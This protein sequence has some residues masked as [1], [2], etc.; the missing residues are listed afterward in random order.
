ML[1]FIFFIG[2]N[3]VSLYFGSINLVILG[4]R[5]NYCVRLEVVLD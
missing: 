5:V 1:I 4:L 2:F 3:Y